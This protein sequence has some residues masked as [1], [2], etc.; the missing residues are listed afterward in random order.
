MEFLDRDYLDSKLG[1]RDSVDG[2]VNLAEAA[3]AQ[4]LE[5]S[6]VLD[7]LLLHGGIINIK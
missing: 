2:F 7:L 1:I 4:D 6:V 3:L 5:K